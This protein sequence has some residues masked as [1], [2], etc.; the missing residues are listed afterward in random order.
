[1]NADG[2]K[3]DPT[4]ALD[5]FLRRQPGATAAEAGMPDLSGLFQKLHP[6]RAAAHAPPKGGVLKD[7]T[8]WAVDDVIDVPVVEL[9]APRP[10]ARELPWLNLP[11]VDLAAEQ[12]SAAA[13]PTIDLPATDLPLPPS[14]ASVAQATGHARDF[15]AAQ[16]LAD[17]QAAQAPAPQPEALALPGHR[18]RNPRLLGQWQQGAWAAGSRQVLEASTEIINTPQGPLIETYPAQYLVA[19]WAPSGR[20]T[21]QLRRWPSSAWLCAAETSALP[22]ALLAQVPEPC[23]MWWLPEQSDLVDWAAVAEIVLI[24]EPGLRPFQSAA[25]R[26]LIERE[27][28]AAFARMNDHYHRPAAGAP[29]L[30]KG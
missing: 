14:G 3:D 29:V 6:D 21:P 25:L 2:R 23:A 5:D 9:R 16:W 30:R 11:E 1:M 20:S 28:E 8:A 27:R 18:A 26:S 24:H 4:H 7:G 12:A 19:W 15:A 13:L 17:A 22:D 10:A